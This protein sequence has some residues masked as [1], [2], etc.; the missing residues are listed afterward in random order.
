MADY[1]AKFAS[2][3]GVFYSIAASWPALGTQLLPTAWWLLLQETTDIDFALR[4]SG[5]GSARMVLLLT[6]NV[7]CRLRRFSSQLQAAGNIA[8]LQLAENAELFNA[9]ADPPVPENQLRIN[10]EGYHH[11]GHPLGCDFRLFSSW[12]GMG[13]PEGVT[14]QVALR[15]NQPNAEQERRVRKYHAWLDQEHPFTPPVQEMQR[16]LS[17]RLLEPGWLVDEYLLFD[18]P[19]ECAAWQARI[20]GQFNET[21]GRIGFT[22]PPIEAGDFSDWLVTGCHSSRDGVIGTEVSVLG[23]NTLAR[24]EIEWL[25]AQGGAAPTVF[26]SGQPEAFV[27]YA[28]A[29]F[30][31]ADMVRRFLEEG[32][33]CCWIAPRDINSEGLPYTEAIP[34]A[35]RQVRAVVVLLSAS[36]NLSVHIPRELDLALKY[37]RPIIPLRL[38]DTIPSGQLEYLLQTCQWLNL[39]NQTRDA[40]MQELEQRLHQLVQV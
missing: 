4:L 25:I 2:E 11:D 28:S 21:T 5:G 34:K 20:S 10:H 7:S 39:F 16:I 37:R 18:E 15:A 38:E 24:K 29:D 12:V 27:S 1:Q 3:S 33:R 8:G 13:L 31:E 32:G 9:M 22:E 30:T 36:A 19:A 23:A 17:N 6:A 26:A 35:I 40:A 14:Y